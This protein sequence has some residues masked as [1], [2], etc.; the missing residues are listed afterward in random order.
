M[1][2]Y[3]DTLN[4]YAYLLSEYQN[5]HNVL[6]RQ[7]TA[8]N[9]DI[10]T[11]CDAVV[12]DMKRHYPTVDSLPLFTMTEARLAGTPRNYTEDLAELRETQIQNTARLKLL[13][14]LYG[15]KATLIDR[16]NKERAAKTN[17]EERIADNTAK[18]AVLGHDG[19]RVYKRAK[20]ISGLVKGLD[21]AAAQD[22]LKNIERGGL[23][24]ML[25]DPLWLWRRAKVGLYRQRGGYDVTTDWKI[26]ANTNQQICDLKAQRRQHQEDLAELINPGIERMQR[27][28]DD[29]TRIERQDYSDPTL[30]EVFLRSFVTS[31]RDLNVS[32]KLIKLYPRTLW[33]TA[34]ASVGTLSAHYLGLEDQEANLRR[35]KEKLQKA[36]D[37]LVKFLDKKPQRRNEEHKIFDSER[38]IKENSQ[39]IRDVRQQIAN[40]PSNK[41]AAKKAQNADQSSSGDGASSTD[42]NWWMF[43]SSNG[44]TFAVSPK[45]S[46]PP[47][48][49]AP[50]LTSDSYPGGGFG[51]D[52]G[53][54]DSDGFGGDGGFSDG[55]G[56][57][58]GGGGDGGGGGDI[59]IDTDADGR[60]LAAWHPMQPMQ[61]RHVRLG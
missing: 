54:W 6:L 57:G 2:T 7:A 46:E 16:L 53:A 17:L 47:V 43:E 33:E 26:V 27:H 12:E 52:G 49:D 1:P 28:F 3:G 61:P 22:R 23:S 15:N 35:C 13:E 48:A 10:G 24:S 40:L 20:A 41:A 44:K 37:R 39:Y 30:R 5:L 19:E 51:G 31:L 14:K 38:F 4:L 29:F 8:L 32:R 56:G 42:C 50:N 11:V 45:F 25:K 59:Y 9:K 55:G 36:H 18:I 60:P 34:A 58:D 21:E